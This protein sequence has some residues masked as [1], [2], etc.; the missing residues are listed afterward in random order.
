MSNN[1]IYCKCGCGK[2]L[3]NKKKKKGN[4]FFNVIHANRYHNA[5]RKGKKIGPYKKKTTYI[6][7]IIDTPKM[8]INDRFYYNGS[9]KCVGYNDNNIEC[10]MCFEENMFRKKDCWRKKDG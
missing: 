1:P 3:S 6:S 8:D 9:S 7:R 5:L 2:E 4:L 10:V